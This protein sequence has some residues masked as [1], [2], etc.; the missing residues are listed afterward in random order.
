MKQRLK[1]LFLSAWYPNPNDAMEG[2]FVRK[3]A[4]AVSS[5]CDVAVLFAYPDKNTKR[6]RIEKNKN[7]KVDEVLVFYPCTGKI[8]KMIN[9]FRAYI[10]GY[11]Y[12]SKSGFKPDIVHVNVL[13]RMGIIAYAIKI[14]TGIPYVVT[15]H[16]SR[17]FPQNS[18]SYK[19]FLR[20]L[21]TKFVVRRASAVMPVSVFLK[22]AM[23]N[24]GLTNKNYIVVNNVVDDFFFQQEPK[25]FREK[26]R[27]LHVSCFDER[28]K[29]VCGILR[30]IKKLSLERN[31][32][33]LILIGDGADFNIAKSCA[34][35]LNLD[36]SVVSFLGEKPPMEVAKWMKNSDFFVLFSNYENM[37][38]V[39]SE[40]LVSGI[41]VLTVD[42]G[43][44]SEMVNK[45][46]GKLL[47]VGDENALYEGLKNM[48]NHYKE[49]DSEKIIQ[50]SAQKFSYE[51]VG[52]SILQVYQN[53]L[54]KKTIAC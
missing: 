1:S 10:K 39:I 6:F 26:K 29:N 11:R 21:A 46:N 32:F 7:K 48:L 3:H 30:A 36:S 33:E 2:L 18:Q 8:S 24:K 53:A 22:N 12:L 35:E 50:D 38:V 51:Y 45:I 28:T 54:S 14:L 40:S 49:Y 47:Q 52:Q 37:P 4:E 27:I 19:G 34:N 9:F 43:G 17:Y 42:T 20:K 25:V 15:E 5:Y 16:W 13:T 23:I 44:I 31:D 41:P